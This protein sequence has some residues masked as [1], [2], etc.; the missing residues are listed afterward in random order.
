LVECNSPTAAQQIQD[1]LALATATDPPDP[2]ALAV[3]NNFTGITHFCNNTVTVTFSA[4]DHCDNLGTATS[5][6]T[7]VD[8]EDPVWTTAAGSLDRNLECNDAARF[9]SSTVTCPCCD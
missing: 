5:T 6:I 2:A 8:T 4:V 7:I 1:W 3:S 9:G